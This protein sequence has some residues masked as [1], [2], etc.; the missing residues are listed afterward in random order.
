MSCTD[1]RESLGVY[2]L[3]ALSM[4]ESETIRGHLETCSGCYAEYQDL[5]VLTPLLGQVSEDAL[6][7]DRPDPQMLDRLLSAMDSERPV[8]APVRGAPSG[9]VLAVAASVA[10]LVVGGAVWSAGNSGPSGA[11]PDPA[12]Q[13]QVL[14]DTVR[15]ANAANGVEARV[16]FG[17]NPAGTWTRS[18]AAG[19]PPGQRCKLVAVGV[20][21]EREVASTWRTGGKGGEITGQVGLNPKAISHFE[22]ATFDDETLV[23]MPMPRTGA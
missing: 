18:K 23:V 2:V 4:E 9:R 14:G 11:K 19:M 15:A 10:M 12:G 16:T 22:M 1:T 6:E 8:R 3:G 5:A 13:S 21:G 17:G 20:N 7:A